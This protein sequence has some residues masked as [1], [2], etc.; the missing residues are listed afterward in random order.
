MANLNISKF[1]NNEATSLLEARK[2][3]IDI[4]GSDIRA[5]GNEVEIAVRKWLER[6]L[7]DTVSIG[8][9]HIIDSAS[10][11]SPQLDCILR[12]RR[13]IPTLFTTADGTEY[14]PIDSVFSYGEIKSTYY[15]SSKYI[16]NFA[17]TKKK[18]EENLKHF[19]CFQISSATCF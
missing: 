12:D 13:H 17:N 6:M 3:C 11:T 5:A 16:E 15:K 9:G 14:T 10:K 7:P 8:H 2:K 4:H 1:F 18:I 19:S